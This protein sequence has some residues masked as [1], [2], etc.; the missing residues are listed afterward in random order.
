MRKTLEEL[1]GHIKM[2]RPP[3]VSSS[4]KSLPLIGLEGQGEQ[5][6]L[7]V[8]GSKGHFVGAGAMGTSGGS[9]NFSCC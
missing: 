3:R 6:V 9:G 4:R 7:L 1:K 2:V 8:P 5:E